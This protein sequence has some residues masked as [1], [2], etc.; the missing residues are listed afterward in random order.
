MRAIPNPR[1]FLC[2][3]LASWN[4]LCRQGWSW[5]QRY[6]C[7]WDCI[8]L[9]SERQGR[10]NGSVGNLYVETGARTS[11]SL[12]S[13]DQV[14]SVCSWSRCLLADL[15]WIR[16]GLRALDTK[17]KR[18]HLLSPPGLS[19]RHSHLLHSWPDSVTII[20]RAALQIMLILK[21]LPPCFTG[22]Y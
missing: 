17:G 8:L 14:G 4:Q 5:S 6:A 16:G 15:P 7:P 12:P 13:S 11:S 22:L 10:G 3:A 2:V 20:P 9:R 19:M 21:K 18:F 1:R